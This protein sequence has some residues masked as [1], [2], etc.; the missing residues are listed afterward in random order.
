[1]LRNYEFRLR[2]EK[3]VQ[4]AEFRDGRFW[5]RGPR[6]NRNCS[7][8]QKTGWQDITLRNPALGGSNV[9]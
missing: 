2:K 5:K 7:S 9:L 3:R 6:E 4:R 1:M 8:K